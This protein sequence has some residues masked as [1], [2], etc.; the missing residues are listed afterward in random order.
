M[1]QCICKLLLLLTLT[2][3]VIT[4]QYVTKPLIIYLFHQL[5]NKPI[6]YQLSPLILSI[7]ITLTTPLQ[8]TAINKVVHFHL[9]PLI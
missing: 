8:L 6:P 7:I 2:N 9:Y 1:N 3:I 5:P 4:I